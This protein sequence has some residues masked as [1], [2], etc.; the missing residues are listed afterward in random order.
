MLINALKA[1]QVMF[2]QGGPGR[3][4]SVFCRMF[5][6][7]VRQKI[8]PL[9]IPVLIRLRDIE[10]FEP[11]FENTLTGA[12][13][14]DFARDDGWLTDSKLRFLFILDGFDELRLEGRVSGGI[15]RFINQVGLY[16]ERC[17]TSEMG[18]RFIVTGRQLALQDINYLPN[19]LERVE[20]LEMNNDLQQQWLDRWETV[21]NDDAIVAR[22]KTEDFK[23]FLQSRSLPQEVKQ[24]LAREPLLLYLLA[25]MH[26]DGDINVED[27]EGTSGIQTK[28]TIYEKALNWVLIEQRKENDNDV[29]QEIVRLATKQ[30]YQVLMEAGLSVVQSGEDCARIKTIEQ[31]LFNSRP[32]IAKKIKQ[33]RT[34]LDDKVLKNALAAF[35]LKQV[36]TSEDDEGAVEFFHESFGEFLCA[37]R[38]QQ[39]IEQWTKWDDDE[40]E[41]NLDKNQ[42]AEEIYDLLGYGG[43]TPEIV[44]YLF[45]LLAVSDKFSSVKLFNRLENFFLRWCDGKFIDAPPDNNYPQKKMRLLK[46]QKPKS[47]NKKDILGLRQ[48]DIYTGLN[49][50]ILQLELRRY[51]LQNEEL[52]DLINFHPC[53]KRNNKG[54]LEDPSLLFRIIGYSC[55]L[56]EFS[57]LDTI[58]RFL[59]YTDLSYADLS[60]ADLILANLS[61]T[62]LSY[63]ILS[64]TNLSYANLSYANLRE[65]N[66]REANLREANLSYADL[67]KANLREANLRKAN[68]GD[69][70]LNSVNLREAN[71]SYANLS[72]ANLSYADLSYANLQKANLKDIR[73]HKNTNWLNVKGLELAINVPE[74]LKQQFLR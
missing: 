56:G 73:W 53:G 59:S 42:L 2:I 74:E 22:E 40:D 70:Q 14:A 67:R 15:E 1:K 50:M 20:L 18:H 4:K 69:T 38:M 37:K 47:I 24:E 32:K 65:A 26:R 55:C 63:T 33:I 9:W 25:A 68:L 23:S 71:L 35:Y 52:K 16:Q 5:A 72:Y 66:L 27:L 12:V 3:G 57:F 31:R 51:A 21:V 17:N 62:N 30:V 39:S 43:L 13:K 8:H 34:N 41:F 49:V 60:Y 58:G 7:W 6:D 28:I 46:E 54:E 48:V 61:Y 36:S 10:S 29:N 19:N 45:G 44:E 64:C 11:S